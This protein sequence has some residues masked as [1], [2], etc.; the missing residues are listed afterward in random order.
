MSSPVNTSLGRAGAWTRAAGGWWGLL[1][2]AWAVLIWAAANFWLPRAVPPGISYYLIQPLLWLAL[3]GLAWLGWRAGLD[4]RPVP[5][6]PLWVAALLIGGLQISLLILAGLWLGFVRTP[7][8]RQIGA[9]LGNL[10]Y[11]GTM[12]AGMEISRAYLM[13]A[14]GR[15]RPWLALGL[16]AVFF[17]WLSLPAG[18]WG[19]LQG[20]QTAVP[21]VGATLLPALFQNLL[22]AL[23]AL[24][25][26]PIA[27][28]A[29]RGAPLVFEWLSPLLPNLGWLA[30]AALGILTPLF[31]FLFIYNRFAVQQDGQSKEQPGEGQPLISWLLVAVISLGLLGLNQGVF[32]VNSTLVASGSMTPRLRVGDVVITQQVPA[33]RVRVND[34]IRY[35]DRGVKII[36]RVV[37][38]QKNGDGLIFITRG[39]A[40][41]ADDPPVPEKALDGKVILTVPKIGWVTIGVRRLI[42]G[43][44]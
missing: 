9:L 22:A 13:V 3:A 34:I 36:H 18:F 35:S 2:A 17:A 6:K 20:A 23:L 42:A 31:G 32:G 21:A 7:Y 30:S 38:I 8:A 1:V 4:E 43:I 19:S 14:F 24:L 40:N 12:L 28:I 33:E 26:G 37:A 11:A 41:N 25:G 16:A 27:S 44:L 39:D 29:Y 5:P 10:L 15:R